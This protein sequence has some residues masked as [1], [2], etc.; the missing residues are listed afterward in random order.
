MKNTQKGFTLIE[1]LVVVAIIGMLASVVVVSLNS[2]RAKARDAKRISDMKAVQNA[3]E[4]YYSDNG[5]YPDLS[6]T[7]TN[8]WVTAIPNTTQ[9]NSTYIA[10]LPTPPAIDNTGTCSTKTYRYAVNTAKS[11]YALQFCLNSASGSYAAGI[12]YISAG[13]GIQNSGTTPTAPTLTGITW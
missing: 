2:A 6:G 12:N 3:I 10:S 13:A 11:D 8:S 1:L 7:V 4:M 5:Q 9:L